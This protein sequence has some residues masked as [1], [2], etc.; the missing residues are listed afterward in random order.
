MKKI[1]FVIQP[2]NEIFNK[3]YKDIYKP[4]IESAGFLPYRVDQDPSVGIVFD[5]IHEQIGKAFVCLA[6]ITEDNPNVWYELGF[7]FAKD[8]SVIMICSEDRLGKYPFDI[9]HQKIIKYKSTS[10]SDFKELEENI[11]GALLSIKSKEMDSEINTP[12]SSGRSK[13]FTRHYEL[14]IKIA[15]N[16]QHCQESIFPWVLHRSG[17][18]HAL[19]STMQELLKYKFLEM[20]KI[21]AEEGPVECIKITQDGWN[22]L[23][24]ML[25]MEC[26]EF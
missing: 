21:D 4:A 24:A 13:L 25:K 22:A 20:V 17:G 2:F 16:M 11:I 8:K 19:N 1:C 14:L 9:S 10:L 15:D 18:G 3:R 6:D 7:S 23:N 12:I 5:K 26:V